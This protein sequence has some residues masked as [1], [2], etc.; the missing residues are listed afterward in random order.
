MS[1]YRKITSKTLNVRKK[2]TRVRQV[3]LEG[4][5]L[6]LKRQGIYLKLADITD[7]A[8]TKLKK[9][10]TIKIPSGI[11][12]LPP[13]SKTLYSYAFKRKYLLLPRFGVFDKC[14]NYDLVN[15]IDE[16]VT[17]KWKWKG[18]LKGNQTIIFNYIMKNIFNE[19]QMD[20]GKAGCIL[21]LGAGLGKSFIALALMIALGKKCLLVTHS[22]NMVFQWAELIEK[23]APG[24]TVGY[25]YGKKKKDGDVVLAIINTMAG[26][27]FKLG[28]TD[29]TKTEFFEMF[30]FV[31]CDEC[32]LMLSPSG[33]KMYRRIQSPYMIGLSA[34]PAENTQGKDCIAWWN[35]GPV[36][37]AEEIDG[38]KKSEVKFTGRVTMVKYLGPHEF[39]KLIVNEKMGVT[40][41]PQM[42]TQLMEDP[43]RIHIIAKHARRLQGEGYMT[44]IFADRRQY[45]LDIKEHMIKIGVKCSMLEQKVKDEVKNKTGVDSRLIDQFLRPASKPH[46]LKR[47]VGGSTRED[48]TIAEALSE[49]ILTTYQYMSVGKSIPK[50][51]AIILASPRKNYNEQTIKRIFRLGSDTSIERQIIDVVDW[52]THMKNQ[53]YSRKKYFLSQEYPIDIN[54]VEW[55]SEVVE[56]NKIKKKGE[57]PEASA[58]EA[59]LSEEATKIFDNLMNG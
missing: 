3:D 20:L 47:L 31:I 1:R 21:K 45:L 23:W 53:W 13:K 8:F 57:I 17:K 32:Q 12:S 6:R 2:A 29:Y 5:K 35:L 15:Q 7:E 4:A 18:S 50:M 22:T 54:K 11:P 41:V 37:D 10:F 25:C 52:K 49:V 28:K 34:T 44:F 14:C 39:T 9:V 43:Y 38:Y 40:A 24:I 26:D 59:T 27:K 51:N 55:H 58:E 46:V 30:D 33:E 56:V 16:N 19:S 36:L 48:M 42:I